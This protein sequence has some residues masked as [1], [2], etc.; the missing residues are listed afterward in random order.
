MKQQNI[1]SI[2]DYI[3]NQNATAIYGSKLAALLKLQETHGLIIKG[4]SDLP[5]YM[6]QK[7]LKLEGNKYISIQRYGKPVSNFSDIYPCAIKI[8]LFEVNE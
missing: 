8:T 3:N 1:Q 2:Y 4:F 7:C 5:G 6:N